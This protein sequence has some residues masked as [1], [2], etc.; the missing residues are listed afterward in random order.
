MKKLLSVILAALLAFSCLTAS[1]APRQ[2]VPEADGLALSANELEL[3][4]FSVYTGERLRVYYDGVQVPASYFSWSSGDT[5]VV[6]V[7]QQGYLTAVAPG[8]AVS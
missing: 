5:G 3:P 2:S 8:T 1:A 6:T 7:D 4:M